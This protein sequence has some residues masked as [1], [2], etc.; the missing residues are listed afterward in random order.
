MVSERAAVA[1]LNTEKQNKYTQIIN[2]DA[3]SALYLDADSIPDHLLVDLLSVERKETHE[4]M[5]FINVKY[6]IFNHQ[7]A[8]HRILISNCCM[9]FLTK[10]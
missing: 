5:V 7:Y 2:N 6:N 3:S 4:K 10:P 9:K 1:A 8:K